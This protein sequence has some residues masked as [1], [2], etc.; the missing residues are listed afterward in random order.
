MIALCLR[1]PAGRY[2]AT[3]WGRHVNEAAIAWPP[4]PWRLLRALVAC[5]HRKADRQRF[6]KPVLAGLVDALAAAE[7]VYSLP[8]ATHGH[9][10]HFMPAPVDRT[11]VFDAFARL[12]PDA[13]MVVAWPGVD[14]DAEA[15]ALLDHLAGRLGYLGRAESWVEAAMLP[16]WDGE[17]NTR[18]AADAA[19]DDAAD[20]V[21]LHL[22][23]APD[24]YAEAR[25]AHLA[26]STDKPRSKARRQLEATLP[27]RLV[28]AVAVE[29]SDLQAAGWSDPPA[30]RRVSYRAPSI[31]A[32]RAPDRR[33]ATGAGDPPTVARFVLVGRPPPRIEDVVRIG[34]VMRLAALSQAGWR[35]PGAPLPAVLSGRGGDGKALRAPDHA[36]AFWL[37]EDADGDGEI[38]HVVVY[39]RGGFDPTVRRALDRVTRLWLGG[40]RD[41]PASVEDEDAEAAAAGR[42]EWRL[43]LEGFGG[44]DQFAVSPLLRR[45][46][47]WVSV[48]PYLHPWHAKKGFGWTEQ[49]ARE[50]ERRDGLVLAS[51][52]EERSDIAVGG[53]MR[54][55][56][57]FH[58]FRSRHGLAQPD[59]LG[60]F[61]VL[62]LDRAISGPVALG[63]GC[64]FGLGLFRAADGDAPE[65]PGET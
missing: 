31:G 27:E 41:R 52:P 7:P 57:H 54:R 62:T 23:L 34:E 9:S 4:E 10:R 5:W 53:R 30:S 50:L 49:I 6:P 45:S 1:F 32:G 21:P 8:E 46:R 44:P 14:L 36:H 47:R 15:A 42:K 22:P 60:R 13:E 63:F 55:P 51:A 17:P 56:I 39:A 43:A 61:V 35:S 37:P 40:E 12:A 20:A 28:D 65:D 2:H 38:D 25:A 19:S 26:A 64:H 29:T 18:P 59:R 24:A 3:P 48:T 33:P 58:R 11:L 16:C